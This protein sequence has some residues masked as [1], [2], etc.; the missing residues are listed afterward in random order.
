M[1]SSS[2]SYG[3]FIVAENDL[4]QKE[5][6]PKQ[7]ATMASLNSLAGSLV[8]AIVAYSLGLFAD[9]LGPINALLILQVGVL[10]TIWI[11]WKLLKK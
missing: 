1:A 10:I 8:F 5:Y 2:L 4:L 9:S 6:L 7:R 3:S 11:Y